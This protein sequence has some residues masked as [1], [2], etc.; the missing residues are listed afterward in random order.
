MEGGREGLRK[1]EREHAFRIEEENKNI[2]KPTQVLMR[3]NK[4]ENH[5]TEGCTANGGG[6]GKSKQSK[7]RRRIAFN[8]GSGC[9]SRVFSFILLALTK[10]C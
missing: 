1:K 7:K 9:G 8:D 4:K 3:E 6:R 5:Q 2:K 10:Y